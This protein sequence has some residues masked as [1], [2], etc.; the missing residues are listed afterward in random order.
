[1]SLHS[2]LRVASGKA[3]TGRNVLKRFERLRVLMAN[4]RWSEGQ[5]VLGLPKLKAEKRKVKK[6][7]PKEAAAAAE[8][9][10]GTAGAPAAK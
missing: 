2:S 3:G 4:G 6:A 7:A 8:G 9:A 1:M 5:S 10:A